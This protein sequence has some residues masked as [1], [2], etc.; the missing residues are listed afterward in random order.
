MRRE[1]QFCWTSPGSHGIQ[2]SPEGDSQDT[3]QPSP[4]ILCPLPL[5]PYLTPCPIPIYPLLLVRLP[6]TSFP[7]SRLQLSCHFCLHYSMAYDW[8]CRYLWGSNL[9]SSSCRKMFNCQQRMRRHSIISSDIFFGRLD[10]VTHFSL[11]RSSELNAKDISV[12]KTKYCST[13]F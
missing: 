8:Q 3:N 11:F 6:L 4:F 2:S 9:S 7:V 12:N 10:E 1:F 5:A 13:P